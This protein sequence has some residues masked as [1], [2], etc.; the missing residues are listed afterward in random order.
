MFRNVR[1][2]A[3]P[4]GLLINALLWGGCGHL[5]FSPLEDLCAE[6]TIV[7][8]G[9]VVVDFPGFE[10]Y[11][12]PTEREIWA[13]ERRL[14]HYFV[15]P[16]L[17]LGNHSYSEKPPPMP[18]GFTIADYFVSYEA[19]Q[20]NGEKFIRAK[21]LIRIEKYA[22]EWLAAEARKGRPE[23]NDTDVERVIPL[24]PF[25]GGSSIFDALYNVDRRKLVKFY[26]GAPL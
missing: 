7:N 13:L 18:S 15:K 14:Q 1:T 24:R 19:Y 22:Q 11:W 17:E 25:G 21:G 23:D 10:G 2:V 16:S 4:L 9:S 3:L 20:E 5:A 12:R 26:Y 8:P 6:H